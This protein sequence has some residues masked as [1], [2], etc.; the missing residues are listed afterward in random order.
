M[1]SLPPV[2]ASDP[3]PGVRWLTFNRPDQLNAMNRQLMTELIAALRAADADTEIR[4]IAVTGAGRAF[5]AGADLKEYARQTQAEFDSFQALGH[6]LYVAIEENTKPVIAAINGHCF[7]GGLEI[8]LA[9]DLLV[10]TAGA[11]CGLPEIKLAL[12]PGGGGAQRLAQ[13]AGLS[14]ALDVVLTGRVV[15]AEELQQ[16]GV[17]NHVYPL[18]DFTGRVMQLAAELAAQE[19]APMQM[20]KRLVR[21]AA[22]RIDPRM[23]ALEAEALSRFHAAPAGRAKLEEFL[24]RSEARKK[25]RAAPA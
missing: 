24:A 7:G 20:L 17:I 11:K 4:V 15:L 3:A 12:I 18:E 25:D 8:A 22:P 13:R 19:P 9:C 16:W 14:R 6:E 10:A 21:A 5:M 23:T 2:I 1:N